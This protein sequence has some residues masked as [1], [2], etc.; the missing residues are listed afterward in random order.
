MTGCEP[1]GQSVGMV[2]GCGHWS[3]AAAL[4]LLLAWLG[5]GGMA[6][7][8]P[9]CG[10]PTPAPGPALL[11]LAKRQLLDR[12]HLSERP[13]VTRAVPRAAVASA[14]R[15][16]HPGRARLQG[17]LGPFA[18]WDGPAAEAQGYEIVSFAETDTTGTLV[19][20]LRFEL[21]QAPARDVE[22]VEAQLWLPLRAPG[23]NV[24]LQVMGPDGTALSTR[25]LAAGTGGWLT[26]SLPPGLHG[27]PSLHLALLCH[28]CTHPDGTRLL[29]PGPAR[30]PFVVA[31]AQAR[32]RGRRVGKRSLRCAPDSAL[33][34]LQDYYVD[35][36]NIG[37][38][39]WIIKPEGYQLNY[40]VGQCP[41]HVAGSPGM[42][43]S[44][45]SAVLNLVKANSIAGAGHA[46]C[47]P[48]HRRPLSVLYF[49]RGS[50]IVKT[51]IPD[52]IVEAC[53]CS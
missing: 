46:C 41:L 40:C 51:D 2:P 19:P 24:T 36:R 53:G 39:D 16:L 1:E 13:N 29:S 37:W 14:L 10:V 31:R 38:H 11:E 15:R 4:I 52:M 27:L 17:L 50:N 43:A 6:M 23:A 5:P 7:G 3:W 26:F 25:R 28:G 20:E 45:H 30:R 48:T 8:C 34:C 9:G 47:V 32:A 18:A 22:I 33:C 49:D 12:L 44:F 42:A 35:F 21:S